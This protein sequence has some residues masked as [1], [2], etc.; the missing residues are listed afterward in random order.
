MPARFYP[1]LLTVL[2]EGYSLRRLLPDLLAGI[3]VGVVALPLAIAFAIASGVKPEQGLYTAIITGFV[4]AM[5]GG[6]RVQVTGPTGAFIVVVYAI[7]QQHGYSGLA[8]ATFMAGC[9]LV[10]MGMARLGAV[11]R[12]IPYS[13]TVG[14]TAGI[15]LIIFSSQV[16][17]FLGLSGPALPADFIGKWRGIFAALES[18]NTAALLL[19]LGSIVL[20]Q[21]WPKLTP[22]VPGSLVAL[23]LSTI[24]VQTLRLPVDTIGSRFGAVPHTLPAPH[25]VG[26][27]LETALT[28]IRPALTIA[29]LGAIES[30]LSAT[31]ADGMLGTRH[32]ANTELVA[33]GVGNMLSPLFSGIPATGAI[34]RTATNIRSGGRTPVAAMTHAIVLLSVLL[35]FGSWAELI[36]MPTLAAILMVVAW[37]MS[38][39]HSVAAILKST[40]SDALIMGSTFIL[41]VLW[42][43]TVAIEAGVLLSALCFIRE[44]RSKL[45]VSLEASSPDEEVTYSLTEISLPPGVAAF[46]LQ[47]PLFYGSVDAFRNAVQATG[48]HPRVLIFRMGGLCSIDATGLKV[49]ES[50]MLQC[51]RLGMQ[52]ILEDPPAAVR[53]AIDRTG[54]SARLGNQNI[55]L[56]FGAAVKRAR[57][58]LA[59]DTA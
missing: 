40:P 22:K 33:Q 23:V 20:I 4:V 57:E 18:L 43:L 36:P 9:L 34:A 1:K 31:V 44:M 13:L 58:V 48:G 24:L 45:R 30:L 26:L 21:L 27:S 15:A 52:I 56:D 50:V 41:T 8:A 42:D 49:L 7:V 28:L 54:V 55:C 53:A 11:L 25:W 14:F 29:L 12:Y 51:G 3:V 10:V 5:L 59:G 38:E 46:E 19:G 17:D 39:R 6:S 2:R 32:R 35:L 16:K 37:N 47:G